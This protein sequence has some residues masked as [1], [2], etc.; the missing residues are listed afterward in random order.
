MLVGSRLKEAR[1]KLGFT[2]S[3]LAKE[4]G[5]SKGAI[6]LY[7]H[8]KRNPNLE[9]ILEMMYLLGVSA[10]YL[11]GADTIVEV[12]DAKNPKYATLTKEE[13]AFINELRKDKLHY[14]ILFRDYKRGIEIIKQRL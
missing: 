7:E 2:Q 1:E 12:K 11:L 10:D 9:T 3:D 4:L 14:D 13:I 5:L 6:S 8:E